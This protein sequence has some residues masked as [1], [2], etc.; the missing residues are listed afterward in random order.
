MRRTED[1][2]GGHETPAMEVMRAHKAEAHVPPGGGG[3]PLR[4]MG[5]LLTPK[6]PSQWTGGAYALF[7]VLTPPGAGP[8][9]HLQH[10]GDESFWVLE[11]HYE[12]FVDRRASKAEVGSLI[13]VQKGILHAHRNV[14]GS[15]GRMLAI[16]TPGGLFEGFFEEADAA[17]DGKAKT[18]AFEDERAAPGT[19]AIAANFGIE[20]PPPHAMKFD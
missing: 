18:F 10:R 3:R 4:V 14:G 6:V 8:P 11:G 13:Y 20:I 2:T 16:H 15:V 1:V 7:E 9:P 5:E 17:A 12:F 19:R